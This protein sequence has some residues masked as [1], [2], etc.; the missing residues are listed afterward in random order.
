[1]AYLLHAI[2]TRPHFLAYPVK[3]LPAAA[4]LIARTL[5][6]LPLLTWTVRSDGRPRSAPRAGPTRSSSRAFRP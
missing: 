4:P 3:D 1:M 5:F 6:G 2:R